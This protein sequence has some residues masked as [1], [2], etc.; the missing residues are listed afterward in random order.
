MTE[1]QINEFSRA[2]GG[3]QATVA[4]LTSMWERNDREATEGRRRL[5]VKVDEMKDSLGVLSSR[6]ESLSTDV[7]AMKPTVRIFDTQHQQGIG[8]KKTIAMIWSI[9]VA[10]IGGTA[11]IVVELIHQLWGKH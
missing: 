11:A 6:V 7:A 4:S 10:F 2:L 8:T 9:I 3:L 1:G 5:Y